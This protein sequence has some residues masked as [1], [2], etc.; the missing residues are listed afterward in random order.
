[1]GG[2]GW[3]GKARTVIVTRLVTANITEYQTMN[4]LSTRAC[5]LSLKG[6]TSSNL[7]QFYRVGIIFI[8]TREKSK[9]PKFKLL[10]CLSVYSEVV[11]GEAP[12]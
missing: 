11:K 6:L 4:T 1:M 9:A 10:A 7:H 2:G 8:H 5:A 12:L 3:E